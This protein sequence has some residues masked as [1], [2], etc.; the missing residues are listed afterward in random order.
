MNRA[1]PSLPEYPASALGCMLLVLASG[2]HAQDK[3]DPMPATDQVPTLERV[4]ALPPEEDS[5]DLYRFENPIAVDPNRFEKVYK[6]EPSPEEIAMEHGGYI[7]YG[8]N[9]ALQKSWQGIKKVTGMRAQS[10]PAIARP[11]PLDDEQLRRAA[12]LCAIEGNDCS[13]GD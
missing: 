11:P 13:L 12:K 5:L 4:E 7:N 3:G 2:L 1:T 9:L 8:I 10:Q 6:P